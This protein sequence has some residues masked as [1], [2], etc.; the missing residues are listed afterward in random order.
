M[1]KPIE[2]RVVVKPIVE[3][4]STTSSGFLIS[5]ADEKPQEAIVIAVGP[6]II[7]PSGVQVNLDLKVGDKVIFA[8][9][10]GTEVTHENESYLVLPYRDILA[11]LEEA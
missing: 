10:S 7:L 4:I 9:Y 6:G 8:K 1:L 5:K 3:D 11:V 2:D